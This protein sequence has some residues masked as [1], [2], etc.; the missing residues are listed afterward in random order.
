MIEVVLY[1]KYLLE[2][3]NAPKMSHKNFMLAV[4]W[5][6]ILCI[7]IPFLEWK[8][9]PHCSQKKS[10]LCFALCSNCLC[11]IADLYVQSLQL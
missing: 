11:F 1:Q 4:S 6:D 10:F 9:V 7:R 3:T 2:E 5:I 8:S